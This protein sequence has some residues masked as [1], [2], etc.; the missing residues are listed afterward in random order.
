MRVLLSSGLTSQVQTQEGDTP[1]WA[2]AG[3]RPRVGLSTPETGVPTGP[4]PEP[5]SWGAV[6]GPCRCAL[7]SAPGTLVAKDLSADRT[8]SRSLCR[9]KQRLKD[10]AFWRHFT[11]SHGQ[12]R[13]PG[14]ERHEKMPGV[15]LQVLRT[16]RPSV[17]SHPPV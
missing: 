6:R 14:S 16:A 1:S 5:S 8:V 2:R 7:P 15:A 12:S 4:C 9:G 13:D 10:A 3:W 17:G 11:D